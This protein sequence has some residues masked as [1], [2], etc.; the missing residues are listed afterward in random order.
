[1]PTTGSSIPPNKVWFGEIPDRLNM[2]NPLRWAVG[3]L[4]VHYS[5]FANAAFGNQWM[6]YNTNIAGGPNDVS[7]TLVGTSVAAPDGTTAN[8]A[9]IVE[10]TGAHQHSII[11]G[12]PNMG[13]NMDNLGNIKLSA[14]LK[15]A[16]RTRAIL[17]ISLLPATTSADGFGVTTA[18]CW[19]C[20]DLAN[21]QIGVANAVYGSNN[22]SGGL[23]QAL[24]TEIVP[25]GNGWYR[26][27]MVAQCFGGLAIAPALFGLITLDNSSGT[28]ARSFDY[29]GNGT[30]G[31]YIWRTTMMPPGAWG[32]HNQI[33]IEDYL[34]N[35]RADFDLADT[36]GPGFKQ[37]IHGYNPG[38]YADTP[39][40]PSAI[41]VSGSVLSLSTDT[42]GGGNNSVVSTAGYV[43]SY[44][45]AAPAPAAPPPLYNGNFFS[46]PALF[47]CRASWIY[48]NGPAAGFPNQ[49]FSPWGVGTQMWLFRAAKNFASREID[50][51]ETFKGSFGTFPLSSIIYEASRAGTT[52]YLEVPTQGSAPSCPAFATL[53]RNNVDYNSTSIVV[54]YNG[55]FYQSAQTSNIGHQPDISTPT[56]W[57]TPVTFTG[58]G[59]Y[60]LAVTVDFTQMHLYSSL[61]LNYTPGGYGQMLQ[62]FDNIFTSIVCTWSPTLNHHVAD[63]NP[64]QSSIL[65]ASDGDP[66]DFKVYGFSNAGTG[67]SNI[68]SVDY[69]SVMQ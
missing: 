65:H 2:L 24:D 41:S 36:R 40:S 45:G 20:F 46:T 59:L 66:I 10:S 6:A 61:V 48:N 29:T 12:T 8:T 50:I 37:Y 26:C 54:I 19:C 4:D 42:S 69:I 49:N 21:G 17:R 57:T 38:N 53:W 60:P 34:D 56:W 5:S 31:L 3:S 18:A 7:A 27:S 25:F 14:F 64:G 58:E 47:E 63:A 32:I 44:S 68:F 1:M 39:V 23:W 16:E 52:D 28:N 62:F 13:G 35:T 43:P 9:K 30:S 67:G 55:V 51:F 22:A 33:F 11:A 15:A